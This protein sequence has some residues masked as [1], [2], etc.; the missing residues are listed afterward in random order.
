M[1]HAEDPAQRASSASTP[2]P[3][4]E[5]ETLSVHCDG[6]GRVFEPLTASALAVQHNLHVALSRPGAVRGN[7]AHRQATETLVVVGPALVRLRLPDGLKDVNVGEAEVCRL[8]LP[9]GVGHAV[10]HRG[11]SEGLLLA[12]S[13]HGY[14]AAQA[15]TVADRLIQPATGD[16]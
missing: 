12:F 10:Q 6:R 4:L 13:T 16:G 8:V 15:D 5:I 11:K 2:P 7:H 1:T 14:P 3:R 9:P